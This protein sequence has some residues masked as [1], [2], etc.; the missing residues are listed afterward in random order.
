MSTWDSISAI[1]QA[2]ND[3]KLS[4]AENVEKALKLLVEKA[5]YNAI[6]EVISDRSKERAQAIDEKIKAWEWAWGNST[7]EQYAAE[8]HGNSFTITT[9]LF[10]K[11]KGKVTSK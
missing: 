1:A 7:S 4:A 5:E 2:V 8:E 3:G 10:E 11:Y 6:I 9:A